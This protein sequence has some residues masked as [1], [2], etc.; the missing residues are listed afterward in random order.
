MPISTLIG[1]P[2]LESGPGRAIRMKAQGGVGVRLIVG[3]LL[4]RRVRVGGKVLVGYLVLVAVLPGVALIVAEAV[5]WG[6]G[7]TS[8]VGKYTARG[9]AD[10]S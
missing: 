3:V 2:T 9:V 5:G 6:R 1:E 8:V 10:S 7:V 4:G